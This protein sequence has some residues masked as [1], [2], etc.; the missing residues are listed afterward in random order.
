M[1]SA[2]QFRLR[3]QRPERDLRPSAARDRRTHDHDITPTDRCGTV[4]L[5]DVVGGGVL[6]DRKGSPL[7]LDRSPDRLDAD[8]AAVRAGLPHCVR[9]PRRGPP[10]EITVVCADAAVIREPVQCQLRL[11]QVKPPREF[12][13]RRHAAQRQPAPQRPETIKASVPAAFGADVGPVLSVAQG[14]LRFGWS[15]ESCWCRR[16][17]VGVRIVWW[18]WRSGSL[19]CANVIGAVRIPRTHGFTVRKGRSREI[20]L[21]ERHGAAVANAYALGRTVPARPARTVR[22]VVG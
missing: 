2:A 8:E 18:S 5:D 15:G 11:N 13:D 16:F 17:P 7:I 6:H 20:E 3:S 9:R 19:T 14:H 21:C 22:L 4:D 10:A 1:P 12:L